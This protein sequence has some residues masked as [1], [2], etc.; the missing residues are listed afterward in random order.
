[1]TAQGLK[2]QPRQTGTPRRTDTSRHSGEGRNP[3]KHGNPVTDNLDLWSS[4]YIKK[5][6]SGRGS[7]SKTSAYGIQKL[8]ELILELAVRGK[9]V[10]QDPNDEPASVLLEKIA[11]EKAR[12]VKEEGL[13]TAAKAGIEE[14]EEYI[15]K[16][17]AWSHCRLGNLAKFIDYR[18]RTPKKIKAG[19]PLI[20]AKNVRFGFISREP[21]EFI[22]EEE[23]GSWMTRGFPRLG[24]V[25][26]TTEA[27]LGNIAIVDIEEKFA[28]AQR[29]I[30]FQLHAPEIAPFLKVLMM[31]LA[32][33]EQLSD[34]ATG[35]TATGIK[36]AKLK[37]ISVPIPPLPEQHRITIKVDELMA[38]C[39]QLEQQQT[40]N[41]T[42]H[43]TLVETLLGTL[44]TTSDQKDFE[45]T[46]QRIAEHF[47]TLFTTEHSIDQLKQTILQLAVMG[48]LVPQNPNDEPASVLLQKI[49]EEKARLAKEKK[50]KKPKP[51]S[52]MSEAEKPFELPMNWTWSR[53]GGLVNFKSKLVKSV[54][55]PDL[56]QVAPDSIEKGSGKLLFRRTVSES[57]VRGPNNRFYAGQIIYSKIR[58]SLNKVIIAD[59]DGLC[60][61]D[62]YPIDPLIDPKYLLKAMLSEVFVA[63]VRIAE[64]RI[65]MPKLNIDS[66]SCM[67]VP[68]PPLPEQHRIVAKVDELMTLCDALKASI[69]AAQ[70]TQ[71]Q[72][73][74]A[75][76][77]QAV[78]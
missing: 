28:L 16:Q 78:A 53:F 34:K 38:L 21:R 73:A 8:R 45:Q 69:Q 75:I 30:C 4:V 29:V 55:Y 43:Q 15:E 20:T 70:T 26:F 77:E 3:E 66:L 57:G 24:D 68:T 56:D 54:D 50:R 74:D 19:V 44:T 64:N 22:S 14:E 51:L 27:P 10:P 9:L 35:M 32:F 2:H 37:E 61:A 67:H 49:T 52:N 18:G 1:M 12:L 41:I 36:A 5:S 71:T 59:F 62:M 39:D 23:Y 33:Q 65:K 13:K 60:S 72:L 48:K 11:D 63:Q 40:E 25:L 31:S 76:V 46:W 58:P 6:A 42:A 47:D 7:N 17:A